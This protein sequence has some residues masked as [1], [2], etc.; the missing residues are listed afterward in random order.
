MLALAAG[1]VDVRVSA[2]SKAGANIGSEPCAG[3]RRNL[4]HGSNQSELAT[5]KIMKKSLHP[6]RVM[7]MPPSNVPKAGPEAWPAEMSELA[8]PRWISDK[9]REMIL[10]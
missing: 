4:S 7:S 3:L 8:R 1:S 5:P 2:L 6:T 10:L 9:W